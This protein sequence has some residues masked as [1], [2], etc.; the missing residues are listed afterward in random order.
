MR[1]SW[2]RNMV[3]T[4]MLAA[5]SWISVAGQETPPRRVS[6]EDVDVIKVDV[7]LVTVNVSVSD[8]KGRC[9]ISSLKAADFFVTEERKPVT[10]QFFDGPGPAS[11]VLV[12]DMSSSMKGTKWRDLKLV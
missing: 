11:I 9:R 10:L 5:L 1:A 4:V 7:G 3:V 6:L 12:V 2:R 8:A